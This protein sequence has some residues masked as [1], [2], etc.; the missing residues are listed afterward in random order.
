MAYNRFGWDIRNRRSNRQWHTSCC[1]KGQCEIIAGYRLD[2]LSVTGIDGKCH[3]DGPLDG[4]RL[5]L[6]LPRGMYMISTYSGNK[7]KSADK[8]FIK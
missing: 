8:I 4:N 5:T 3:Y 7:L 6:A 1:G 2:R